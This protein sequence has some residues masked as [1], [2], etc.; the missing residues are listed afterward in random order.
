MLPPPLRNA[1][2][3]A[4]DS[5]PDQACDCPT[6]AHHSRAFLAHLFRVNE[7]LGARLASLHN[8]HF[9]LRLMQRA[10]RAIGEGRLGVLR[11]EVLSLAGERIR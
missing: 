10:R 4:D 1:R 6:C 11:D 8:L 9:Y 7:S 3:R 5:P 2:F